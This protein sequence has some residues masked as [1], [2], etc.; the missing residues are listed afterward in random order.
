[1]TDAQESHIKQ[2]LSS[3]SDA[4]LDK[5][6]RGAEEHDGNLWDKTALGLLDEAINESLDM[7]V[8][9]FTLRD[10]IV[11]SATATPP[12]PSQQRTFSIRQEPMSHDV[13][14]FEAQ[15]GA[16]SVRLRYYVDGVEVSPVE[17][18]ALGG[19]AR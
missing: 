5:Y 12:H 17:Y 13:A 2:V 19:R 7:V 18:E 15:F 10:K 4:L 11:A 16:P 9:L 6:A 8:Y 3:V 1:M 14:S